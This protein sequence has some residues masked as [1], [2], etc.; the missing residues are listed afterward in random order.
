[1]KNKAKQ[2]STHW[3]KI[4]I[5]FF[6]IFVSSLFLTALVVNF[7]LDPGREQKTVLEILPPQISENEND[8][9]I[10]ASA[11]DVSQISTST[12]I[13]ALSEIKEE[14]MARPKVNLP[15]NLKGVKQYSTVISVVDEDGLKIINQDVFDRSGIQVLPASKDWAI[16][17]LDQESKI[18]RV[19]CQNGFNL[20][21]CSGGNVS[22]LKSGDFCARSVNKNTKNTINLTCSLIDK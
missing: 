17:A 8:S 22:R 19:F 3:P 16:I 11:P 7:S 10:E 9:L 14:D 1:M 21:D 13:E 6:L 5:I 12:E 2:V 20:S 4:L 18:F 15:T